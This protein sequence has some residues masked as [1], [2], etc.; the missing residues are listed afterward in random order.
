M[1]L[2]IFYF[3]LTKQAKEEI[4]KME[5]INFALEKKDVKM[6]IFRL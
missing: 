3:M 6:I 5:K 2:G 1:N 4:E